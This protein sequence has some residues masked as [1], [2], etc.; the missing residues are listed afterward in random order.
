MDMIALGYESILLSRS[1]LSLLVYVF[2]WC[3]LVCTHHRKVVA[4]VSLLA[5]GN[6]ISDFFTAVSAVRSSPSGGALG[7]SGLLGSAL[8]V[9]AVNTGVIAISFEPA[10]NR[11][12]LLRDGFFFV[13]ALG[14]ISFML[15]KQVHDNE[16]F[17]IFVVVLLESRGLSLALTM[18][19]PVGTPNLL[20][21]GVAQ[22]LQAFEAGVFVCIYIVY[23]VTVV[24]QD[25]QSRRQ[26]TRS[27]SRHGQSLPSSRAG[28]PTGGENFGYDPDEDGDDDLIDDPETRLLL[29]L[30]RVRRGASQVFAPITS[31]TTDK[32]STSTPSRRSAPTTLEGRSSPPVINVIREFSVADDAENPYEDECDDPSPTSSDIQ[33][34]GRNR[35]RPTSEPPLQEEDVDEDNYND[36]HEAS[37]TAA[38]IAERSF[39]LVGATQVSLAHSQGYSPRFCIAACCL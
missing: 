17:A 13:V 32:P 19:F 4:G 29:G 8:F 23:G 28:T 2:A 25:L 9:I 39:V 7:M 35:S 14:W 31:S 21:F 15:Y 5:L 11:D 37:A 30:D 16:C 36:E 18:L 10:V 34:V 1:L 12:N 6:G 22:E 33:S 26:W 38:S 20:C 3:L 27:A 24:A